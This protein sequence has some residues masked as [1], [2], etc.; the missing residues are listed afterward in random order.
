MRNRTR[1]RTLACLITAISATAVTVAATPAA[2][3][4]TGS[5]HLTK[6]YL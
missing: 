6:I 3:A 5:V 4:A 2:Q 1:T